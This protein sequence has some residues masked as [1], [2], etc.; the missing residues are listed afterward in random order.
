MTYEVVVVGGGIGGLTTAALLAARGI[1]VCLIERAARAGGCV[2]SHEESGYEFEPAASVY[3]GW[4]PNGIHRRIFAELP[5][6]APE[7]YSA[8][9]AY[10]VRLPDRTQIS[11]T[12]ND[13]EFADS[14]GAAF[15][16]CAAEAVKF[17]K[18]LVPVA[19]AL[20]SAMRRVPDLVTASGLRRASIMAHSPFAMR[21]VTATLHHTAAR[22]LDGTSMRFRRFVDVQLQMLAQLT[23]GDCAY[24]YAALALTMPRCASYAIRGGATA[25]V[26]TL[27]EAI[28]KSGGTVRLNSPVLRLIYG[29]NGRAEGVQLLSGE[30]VQATRAVVSNLT[31]WDTY[32]KLVGADHTPNNIRARLK[33]LRGWGAYLLLLGLDEQAAK[34]LPVDRVLAL[35]D[36]QEEREYQPE[37]AQFMFAAAPFGETRA[38]AGKRAVTVS[39]FTEAEQWFAFHEDEAAH[40][41]QDQRALEFWWQKIHREMPELGGDDVEIIETVTPFD[42]YETTRRKLGMVGGIGQSPDVFGRNALSHLTAIPNL[43]TV[44]DTVFPGQGVAAV[45][46]AALIVANAIAP[47]IKR[48]N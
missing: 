25:L 18:D 27:L 17:Y 30:A 43:Y 32:G 5:V 3:T 13:A 45:T 15:P 29:A 41:A 11:L 35:T 26:N 1:N 2:A 21:R 12:E 48:E 20:E 42:Y 10:V 4:Q 33:T 47:S 34:R 22:Y 16:E 44:G 8:T 9:P 31:I 36:W 37:E 14:L 23:S 6:A 7:V 38:P 40:E 46:H 39:T 24:P 19:D 28:K